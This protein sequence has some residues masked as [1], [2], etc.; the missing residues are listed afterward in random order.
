MRTFPEN[1]P[2]TDAELNR[3]SNSLKGCEGGTAMNL[4]ELDGFFA[5][6]IA[7]PETVMPSEYMPELLGG[8]MSETCEFDSLDEAN[9]TLGL[10]MQHWNTIAETLLKGEVYVP[11][12]VG[13][14]EWCGPW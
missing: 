10:M 14:R 1:K 4:E 9:E 13:G 11:P 6:L 5:A 3:L 8:E 2:L 7:G 12:S